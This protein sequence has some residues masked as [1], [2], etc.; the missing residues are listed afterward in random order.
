MY[1]ILGEIPA[2]RSQLVRQDER[3]VR[4]GFIRGP[5]RGQPIKGEG[6]Y[7]SLAT[8]GWVTPTLDTSLSRNKGRR[9]QTDFAQKILNLEKHVS[10]HVA[11]LRYLHSGKR[12]AGI[13][14]ISQNICISQNL[15]QK[16]IE[17]TR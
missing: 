10:D 1:W 16:L 11:R 12:S 4:T 3:W 15:A 8:R 5:S 2:A 17:W 14:I 13:I 9:S 6:P 7:W